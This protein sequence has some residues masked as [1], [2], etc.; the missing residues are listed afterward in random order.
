MNPSTW[1]DGVVDLIW[2]IGGRLILLAGVVYFLFRARSI[3]VAI[4][5]A[6]VLSYA[7]VPL[8]DFLNRYRIRG[9]NRK[10]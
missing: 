5:L 3:I 4:I 6:A 2:R 8:V 9:V 10:F 1:V 7:A